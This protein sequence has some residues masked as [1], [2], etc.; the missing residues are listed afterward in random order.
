MDIN[1][2]HTVEW[3]FRGDLLKHE[4]IQVEKQLQ[5]VNL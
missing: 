2:G 3:I 4:F 1:L 5:Q